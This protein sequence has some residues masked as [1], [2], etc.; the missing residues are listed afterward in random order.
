MGCDRLAESTRNADRGLEVQNAGAL[1]VVV[2]HRL[3]ETRRGGKALL[4]FHGR[5]LD[6]RASLRDQALNNRS[7]P[8]RPTR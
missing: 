1:D 8:I 7:N 4:S 3:G 2:D 5:W 6:D